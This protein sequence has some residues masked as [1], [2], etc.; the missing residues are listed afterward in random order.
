MILRSGDWDI[1]GHGA[2]TCLASGEGLLLRL[3]MERSRKGPPALAGGAHCEKGV[4]G[5][6]FLALLTSPVAAARTVHRSENTTALRTKLEHEFWWGQATPGTQVWAAAWWTHPRPCTGGVQ[7]V[8][9][10][11]SSEETGSRC[12]GDVRQMSRAPASWRSRELG[13]PC[14]WPSDWRVQ[15]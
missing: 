12:T 7:P 8:S 3:I 13:W 15:G 9:T 4:C 1:Q 10:T 14:S 6:G 2:S 5:Q 11:L